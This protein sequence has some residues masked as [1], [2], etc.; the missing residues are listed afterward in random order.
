MAK[1]HY[2]RVNDQQEIQLPPQLIKELGFTPGDEIRI[3]LN[4]RGLHLRP[5]ISTLKRV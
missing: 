3:E 5:S 1:I 4:G 2:A